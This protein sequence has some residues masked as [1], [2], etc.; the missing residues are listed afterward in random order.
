MLR[1]QGALLDNIPLKE[2]IAAIDAKV[3]PKPIAYLANCT[4][5]SF[6]RSAASD[7][8]NASPLVRSRMIG[9]LANTAALEP[10]ALDNS[11][12]LIAEDPDAFGRDMAR[13]KEDFGLKILGGCCG[14]DERHIGALADR[15][16]QRF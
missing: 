4:H 12:N 10:E 3:H 2:A 5:A 13:L 1:P 6:F 11:E 9:L 14:T 7:Q 8:E 16:I 15:L